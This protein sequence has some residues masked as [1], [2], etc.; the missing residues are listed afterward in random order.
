MEPKPYVPPV[1]PDEFE[2]FFALAKEISR[3]APSAGEAMN[4]ISAYA[5]QL[6]PG[7]PKKSAA[8]A[9]RFVACAAFTAS[10]ELERRFPAANIDELRMKVVRLAAFFPLRG[11]EEFD[12]AAFLEA[13]AIT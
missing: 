1:N 9:E 7:E 3:E 13:L 10:G 5:K 11:G 12:P 8:F 4:K 2:F 6:Y